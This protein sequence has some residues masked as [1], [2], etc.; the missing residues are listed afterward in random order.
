MAC[1]MLAFANSNKS[2][3]LAGYYL[4]F[5]S[6]IGIICVLSCLQSNTAGHTKKATTTAMYYWLLCW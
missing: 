3:R 5:V 2:A 4:Q 1:S 6:P